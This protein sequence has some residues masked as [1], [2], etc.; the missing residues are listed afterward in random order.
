[1]WS[2]SD[3]L[4][5]CFG[6]S[7]FPCD[8]HTVRGSYNQRLS[9]LSARLT[10]YISWIDM[11]RSFALI[12]IGFFCLW[13]AADVLVIAA[14]PSYFVVSGYIF[15]LVVVYN[16]STQ[17]K[18]VCTEAGC[19]IV[20]VDKNRKTFSAYGCCQLSVFKIT[21]NVLCCIVGRFTLIN[22]VYL[23]FNSMQPVQL[24]VCHAAAAYNTS[25][26]SDASITDIHSV[27]PLYRGH[28][29]SLLVIHTAI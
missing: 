3:V 18:P 22:V 19:T 23:L 16:Q 27:L 12:L 21:D 25:R 17:K 9:I 1:M 6:A 26:N 29:L 14:M 5:W 11:V 24:I 13:A 8:L 15:K 4:S 7:K 2:L 10:A 28:A 20:H